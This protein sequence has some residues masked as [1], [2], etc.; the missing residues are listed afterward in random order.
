MMTL[1]QPRVSEREHREAEEYWLFVKVVLNTHYY[2]PDLG[3]ARVLYAA[4]AAHRLNGQP[5]WPMAVA[6][7]GSMKTELIRALDGLERI[8]SID[9]VTSKTFLSGQIRDK[10]VGDAALPSSSLLHRIGPSGVILCPDFSTILAIKS[11]ERK[12]ILADLRRIYDG[13]LKKEFGTSDV[14][15]VWTG[16]ITF[17]A[18]VTPDID[19]HYLAI[20]SLGDRF[21]M[22][23]WGR[24]GQQAALQAMN[25]NIERARADLRAVVH[26]LFDSLPDIEPEV[27]ERMSH[28]LSALAEFAVRGWSPVPRASTGDKAVIGVPEPESA[29]RL[30]QQLCQ[31]AKGSALLSHRSVVGSE[32]FAVARRAGFDSIPARRRTMLDWVIEGGKIARSPSTKKYDAEDLTSL[33]LVRGDGL[34]ELAEQLL[35]QIDGAEQDEFRT[36]PPSASEGIDVCPESEGTSREFVDVERRGHGRASPVSAFPSRLGT[37]VSRMKKRGPRS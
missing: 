24:A 2:E 9:S 30:A 12:A 15:P 14:V 10:D 3:A 23:R 22:V 34:S 16:R 33:E 6:P 18:G 8:H 13:E 32:D 28:R 36:S 20:Q 7:P 1:G 19:K 27:P 11:D 37:P 21:V 4:V 35:R 31:L 25:Q 17:V 29:T 5:V 26:E